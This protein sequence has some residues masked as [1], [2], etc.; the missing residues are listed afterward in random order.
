MHRI[1]QISPDQIFPMGCCTESGCQLKF[2]RGFIFTIWC[3]RECE[4]EELTCNLLFKVVQ[5]TDRKMWLTNLSEN[6]LQ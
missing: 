4:D 2:F 1:I 3:K 6:E 5:P